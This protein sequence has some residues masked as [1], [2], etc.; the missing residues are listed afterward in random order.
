VAV[1]FS[2]SGGWDGRP[3]RLDETA[4]EAS[5]EPMINMDV[6]TPDYFAAFSIPILHGRGFTAADRDGAPR[7]VVLSQSAAR[8]YWPGADPIGRQLN[9]GPGDTATVVGIVRETRYRD[10]RDARPS[11]Y[12]PLQQSFFPFAPTTLAIRVTGSPSDPVPA[13]RQA[14]AAA[15]PAVAV[16][17]I[18][19]FAEF[20]DGPLAQP[21]LNAL[22]LG[23]FSVAALVLAAVGLFGVTAAMVRQRTREMGIRMALGATALQL[24]RMVTARGLAIAGASTAIGLIASLLINRLFSAMLYQ[25]KPVDPGTL[26][27]VAIVTCIVAV[28]ASVIPARWSTRV[29]PVSVL[30]AE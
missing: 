10:L 19:P 5:R 11:I 6:V 30:R 21:R 1:P 12:F 2:G 15:G 9:V 3:S 8:Q 26:A 13:L 20:L 27:G 24:G 28:A 7:V 25:V 17:R 14:I 4:E 18:A 22:L 23:L 29:D 16:V